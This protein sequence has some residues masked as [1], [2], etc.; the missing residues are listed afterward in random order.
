MANHERGEDER[1]ATT[2]SIVLPTSFQPG[3]LNNG[4]PMTQLNR[5]GTAEAK[6]PIKSPL[7]PCW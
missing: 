2:S 4:A 5:L 3:L 7:A 6:K 1:T